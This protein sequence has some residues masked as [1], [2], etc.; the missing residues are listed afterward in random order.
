MTV[1]NLKAAAG[2]CSGDGVQGAHP[3]VRSEKPRY[4]RGVS[5]TASGSHDSARAGSRRRST[6]THA[7]RL[8]ERVSALHGELK[9]FR[10]YEEGPST[11]PQVVYLVEHLIFPVSLDTSGVDHTAYLKELLSYYSLSSADMVVNQHDITIDGRSGLDFSMA[12]DGTFAECQ[13][14]VSGVNMYLVV[15]AHYTSDTTLDPQRFFE[16]FHLT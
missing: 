6:H 16:S 10:Y 5:L 4:P 15:A 14:V 9:V 13:V 3:S 2:W 8:A 7:K 11:D 12:G 1:G